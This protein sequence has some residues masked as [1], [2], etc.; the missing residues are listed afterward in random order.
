MRG[1]AVVLLLALARA[2]PALAQAPLA[3]APAEVDRSPVVS[4][5]PVLAEADLAEAMRSGLPVRLRFRT[6]LWRDEFLDDLVAD[7]EFVLVLRYE[8]IERRYE[9]YDERRGGA[10]G[11]YSTYSRMRAAIETRYGFD[12]RP[13]SGG[14]YYYLSTLEIETL[15]LSD[16]A[17]LQSWLRGE[18]SPAVTGERSVLGAIGNGARRAFIRILGL[19]ARRHEARSTPFRIR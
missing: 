18:L 1:A 9:V 8:P 14:R 13:R 3:V 15:A 10:A 5:G 19:P 6:E 12:M 11:F 16:L 2:T 7:G 4:V 17:E